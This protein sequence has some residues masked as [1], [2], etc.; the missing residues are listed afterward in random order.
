[1]EDPLLLKLTDKSLGKKEVHQEVRADPSLMPKLIEGTSSQK[2][3]VR[4]GCARVLVELSESD[5]LMVY[6]Y[7]NSITD[8]LSSRYRVLKWDAT[9]I[10]AN[11]SLV[12]TE[13]KFDI[14]FDKYY[15]L[16]ND[17]YMVT[18][19]N[20]VR[21]SGKIAV[22]KPYLADRIAEEL[23]KVED[24]PVKPHLTEECKKVIAEHAIRSLGAFFGNIEK[25]REV[26]AF[27]K[28]QANSPRRSLRAEAESFLVKQ[29]K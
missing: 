17:D 6:P 4:Y 7:F 2:A 12:D 22:A 1:V 8:L 20:V 16:I 15:D 14:I 5:P 28:R 10:L 24:I 21:S 26:R 13:R 3:S 25:K 19:A 27:V 11:L 23:L 9:Y 18:V 29:G